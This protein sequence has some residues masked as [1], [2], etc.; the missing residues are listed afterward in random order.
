MIRTPED[1]MT[2]TGY[3]RKSIGMQIECPKC[4]RPFDARAFGDHIGCN[5]CG[6]FIQIGYPWILGNVVRTN[7]GYLDVIRACKSYIKEKENEH[8][9]QSKGY[10]GKL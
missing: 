1:A 4:R 3:V 10:A 7:Q 8:T 9:E 2:G 5:Y 6:I